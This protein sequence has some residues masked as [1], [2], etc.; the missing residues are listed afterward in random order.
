MS[1]QHLSSSGI[2]ISAGVI[3]SD[4]IESTNLQFSFFF[5]ECLFYFI[6]LAGD[7]LIE[8]L[9]KLSLRLKNVYCCTVGSS[10]VTAWCHWGE[11]SWT[12]KKQFY[13]W[14]CDQCF[15]FSDLTASLLHYSTNNCICWT[16]VKYDMISFKQEA[17]VHTVFGNE[18]AARSKHSSLIATVPHV[19]EKINKRLRKNKVCNVISEIKQKRI[20][21]VIQSPLSQSQISSF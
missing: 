17:C 5:I 4:L 1:C 11:G 13:C 6:S 21:L 7:R 8:Q 12:S 10:A 9:S 2:D 15:D 3:K 20:Y 18:E 16:F 14:V 19:A